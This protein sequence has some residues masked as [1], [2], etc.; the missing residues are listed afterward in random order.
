MIPCSS[1]GRTVLLILAV[2]ATRATGGDLGDPVWAEEQNRLPGPRNLHKRGVEPPWQTRQT[3]L[4]RDTKADNE[5]GHPLPVLQPLEHFQVDVVRGAV[6]VVD[7]DKGRSVWVI[8]PKPGPGVGATDFAEQ[9][10]PT[11]MVVVSAAFPYRKQLEALRQA[12]RLKPTERLPNAPRFLGLSVYRRTLG[13]DGRAKRFPTPRDPRNEWELLDLEGK[14]SNFRRLLSDARGVEPVDVN[15]QPVAF[16]GLVMPTPLL[17]LGQYPSIRLHGIP[18]PAAQGQP[19]P[20][21]RAV[22]GAGN[23]RLVRLPWKDVPR[24]SQDWLSGTGLNCW[25]PSGRKADATYR[26]VHPQETDPARLKWDNCLIRFVDVEVKPG[27]AYEYAL[28]VRLANPNPAGGV[29]RQARARPR[30]LISKPTFT[31]RVTVPSDV[32]W[33]A[34]DERALN[35]NKYARQGGAM[36]GADKYAIHTYDTTVAVQVHRW[37]DQVQDPAGRALIDLGGWLV[38]ERLLVKRGEWI[39]RMTW[40]DVPVWDQAA[41]RFVLKTL[42]ARL[43]PRPRKPLPLPVDFGARSA[44]GTRRD[45]L[46]DFSGGVQS[47]LIGSKRHVVEESAVELLVLTSEGRLI[48]R[49]GLD[50]SDPQSAAGKERRTRY[51]AWKK[52]INQLR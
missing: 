26:G 19:R 3:E 23:P 45:L 39:G 14:K 34:V 7:H 17:R 52:W 10:R 21:P 38:A 16:T 32:A 8:G 41:E 49:R 31:P 46:V 43:G 6:R 11:R 24:G 44:P 18:K 36:T 15:Q 25:D 29:A 2:L 27:H 20:G 33:Y 47:T 37:V 28:L 50:D 35:P 13:P 30:E 42:P 4:P 22:A 12:L 9:L 1:T 48:V 5:R 40:V 51:Q